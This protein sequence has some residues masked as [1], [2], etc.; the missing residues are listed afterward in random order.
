MRPDL[1]GGADWPPRLLYLGTGG[2]EAKP[3]TDHPHPRTSV[4]D[5]SGLYTP[6]TARSP[7]RR[8]RASLPHD[9]IFPPISP[10]FSPA[11]KQS[12]P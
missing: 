8:A 11:L 5:V 7:G 2:L 6:V 1:S 9:G 12:K 10:L 3:M 4:K